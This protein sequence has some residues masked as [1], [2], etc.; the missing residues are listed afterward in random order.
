MCTPREPSPDGLGLQLQPRDD[1]EGTGIGLA[2]CKKV[3]EHHGGE[4]SVSSV[5]GEGSTFRFT[6]PD[7]APA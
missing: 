1:Y 2:I 5:A 4:I 7:V 3:V 6:I